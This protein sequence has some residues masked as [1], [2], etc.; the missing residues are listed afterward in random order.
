MNAGKIIGGIIVLVGAVF[1]VI[2]TFKN[3]S[4]FGYAPWLVNLAFSLVAVI[5]GIFGMAGQKGAAI[6]AV[7]AGVLIIFFGL[8][9]VMLP[10]YRFW[11]YSLIA[12]TFGGA[13]LQGITIEGFLIVAGGIEMTLVP[14]D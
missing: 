14:G 4:E 9:S 8:A 12:D 13:R 5:G 6:L 10:D 11:Q 1:M 3:V 7:I 2:Q